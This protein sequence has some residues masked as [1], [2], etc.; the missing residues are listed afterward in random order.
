MFTTMT[1][2]QLKQMGINPDEFDII[3]EDSDVIFDE[4]VV[5]EDDYEEDYE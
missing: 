1:K 5:V 3:Y 4:C 2:K